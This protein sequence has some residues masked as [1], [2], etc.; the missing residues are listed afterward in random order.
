MAVR[1][2]LGDTLLNAG[3]VT[4]LQLDEALAVQGKSG[5]KLGA[6]LVNL[7]IITETDLL[8]T[9]SDAAGIPFLADLEGPPEPEALALLPAELART[10]VAVPVKID[11]RHVV[12]AMADPFD[13]LAIRA[14]TRAV[15]RS[16]RVVGTS[17]DVVLRAVE[18]SYAVSAAAGGAMVASGGGAA[19]T[20]ATG[21][22]LGIARGD[23]P[24][25][26]A[27]GAGRP[28][29]PTT[30]PWRIGD[31]PNS[32]ASV[33]SD[34]IR[35]GVEMSATDIHIEPRETGLHIRYRV[36]GLLMD[37]PVFPK[38]AQS[39]LISRIKILS[40]LDIADA[41]LPQDGRTQLRV[42]GRMVDLRVSTFPTLHGE[43]IVLRILDRGNVALQLEKLG[44]EPD[45]L[46]LLR[47]AL[48]RPHG[49]IPV[50]G[51]TGSGK[52]TTLYAALSELSTGD[53]AIITLE[54]PIEYELPLIR[55]SQ[56][57]VRAGLTFATGLRSILRHDPDVILVG[58]IRDQETA[59]IAMS[60]A[61]TGH[62]VLTTLHTTTAAGTIPRL[63]DMGIEPFVIAS[64]ITM[65]VSQRLVRVLCNQCKVKI[66]VQSAVR[67]RFGLENAALYGPKG[68]SACRDTGY[69]GRIGI[70]EILPM[71]PEVVTAI[72]ERTAPEEIHR[73]SGRPTLL[74]DGVRK[75]QAGL[76]T[77]DEILRVTT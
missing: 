61:L 23:A 38:S 76:T 62:L 57:N 56:V 40:T 12:V 63:L 21:P 20:I 46:L 18:Q 5:E 54:D 44:V 2:W 32:A 19:P 65:F 35:R 74:Q 3:L 34:L 11:G 75:V 73:N 10:H 68:C 1:R 8:R 67:R 43:D 51:P 42:A 9:L 6:V 58:E 70:I 17:R 69:R 25:P 47:N 30:G 24:A 59:Q 72:Y 71:S 64:S 77:L 31:D 60:A 50:T 41:R 22:R 26:T 39:S 66:D 28:G 45:D 53:R 29:W 52:T 55:Q 13:L 14:L 49:L 15:G 16:V 36:D 27:R 48:Q 4:K 7:G 37:G 33:V